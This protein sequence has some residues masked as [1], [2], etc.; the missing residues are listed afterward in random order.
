MFHDAIGT[1]IDAFTLNLADRLYSPS[2]ILK[3]WFCVVVTTS[4]VTSLHDIGK[5]VKHGIKL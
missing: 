4:M 5:H 3:M 2:P 1:I